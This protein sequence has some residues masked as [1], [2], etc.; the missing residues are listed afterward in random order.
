MSIEESLQHCC[1]TKRVICLAAGLVMALLSA[2]PGSAQ[3]VG[4]SINMVTGITW[5][6]GDPFLERQNEPSMAVSSRN[7]LHLIAGNNDYRTVDLPGLPYD[8]P[9]GDAWLGFFTSI[10]GGNSWQ[11]TLVPG[12]P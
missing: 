6:T 11:S 12:Y 5:P 8:E 1:A 10:D 7:P 4:Q 9:T 2:H 3:V